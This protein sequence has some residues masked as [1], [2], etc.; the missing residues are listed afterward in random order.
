MRGK[1]S[2]G[3]LA[4]AAG[5]ITPAGAGKTIIQITTGRYKRDHPRR[6]GEN[7]RY[8]RYNGD[9][10]GSPP[11]VRGKPGRTC[12]KSEDRRITPA[13]AGK[14]QTDG[15]TCDEGWDHPRRCGENLTADRPLTNLLGS[16][17]QVRGKPKTAAA[18]FFTERITPAGAGK[19]KTEKGEPKKEQDHPRRCG[20]NLLI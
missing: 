14:T 16:P 11:Q 12:Y 3:A 6:C 7:Q 10:E 5:G 15:F 19:T 1:P 13:G 17:P 4:D 2:S 18:Q 9:I 8:V 20:E